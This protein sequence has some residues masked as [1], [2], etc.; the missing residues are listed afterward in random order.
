MAIE[1]RNPL[2][3][4]KYWVD[5][6]EPH[7]PD[8]RMWLD[9]HEDSIKIEKQENFPFADGPYPPHN[10]Y[11]FSVLSETPWEGPGFPDI[12]TEERESKDTADRGPA[13]KS[14]LESIEETVEKAGNFLIIGALV[15]AAYVG[16][17]ILK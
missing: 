6:F 1:R 17:K 12:A 11:L 4:G 8:F 7:I 13:E 16:Y 10:W 9:K 2:P 3:V 5:V 15:G 14:G